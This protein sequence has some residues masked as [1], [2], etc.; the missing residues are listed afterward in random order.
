MEKSV[1]SFNY[2]AGIS[3]SEEISKAFNRM[4]QKIS[5]SKQM[6][7]KADE[8][9]AIAQKRPSCVFSFHIFSQVKGGSSSQ[10]HLMSRSN[11]D[12]EANCVFLPNRKIAQKNSSSSYA[13][14]F[15]T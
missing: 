1:K 14:Q 10:S 15:F 12:S 11:I 3:R 6:S 7:P 5:E 13:K 9:V 4:V 8:N 2:E